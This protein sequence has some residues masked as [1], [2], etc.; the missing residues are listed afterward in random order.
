M[1]GTGENLGDLLARACATSRRLRRRGRR[2]LSAGPTASVAGA[3]ARSSLAGVAA[4]VLVA[5]LGYALTTTL[6]PGP[7]SRD[8][9]RGAPGRRRAGRA[10][11][12]DPVLTVIRAADRRQA[13]AGSCPGSRPRGTGW[14]QYT[15]LDRTP[16]G[17]AALIE[18]VRRTTRRDGFCF[19]VLADPDA[20]ARP[21]RTGDDIE[22][23]PVRRRSGTWTGRC[24][25]RSPGGSSDGRVVAVMATGERG[26]GDA[27]PGRPPLTGGAG[28]RAATDPRLIA[29][30]GADER[31]D[32]PAPACPS[33]GSRCRSPTGG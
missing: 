6:L 27:A 16:A 12:A 30:F 7:A 19:P 33:A 32:G 2:G 11:P 31:C 17:R 13:A 15:V 25:R 8:A 3:C 23:A 18:V 29:A 14:R 24:T 26:T 20:C 4:V 22:Y 5:A 10:A 1:T 21:E 9:R 28:R